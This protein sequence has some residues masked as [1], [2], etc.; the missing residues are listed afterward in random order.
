MA[1]NILEIGDFMSLLGSL[2]ARSLRG[3]T[4]FSHFLIV[5][6]PTTPARRG[7]RPR[8]DGSEFLKRHVALMLAKE[9]EQP[10]VIFSL[11]VEDLNELLEAAAGLFQALTDDRTKVPAREIASHER[12]V[13]D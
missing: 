9:A 8:R 6:G 11:H 1:N 7:F 3:L 10:L 5:F 12:L 13:N 4:G 2:F